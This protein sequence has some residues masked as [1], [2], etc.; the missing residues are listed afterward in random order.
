VEQDIRFCKT[1]DGVR[2]A[3]AT[4]GK[5]DPPL[6]RVLGWFTHLE[7]E[8]ENPLWRTSID[9][10]SENHLVVRYD[11]RCMGLSDRGVRTLGMETAVT[12]LETVI[13]AVGLDKVALMGLSAGGP[14]AIMYALRYPDRVSHLILYGTFVRLP[15]TVE[16]RKMMLEMV[17]FGWDSD[18]SA[19]RQFF[20]SLFMP[21]NPGAD[22]IKAFNDIQR[23]SATADDVVA[24]LSSTPDDFDLRDV[25]PQVRT[26]TLVVH[27]RGD[28]IVPFE[29]GREIAAGIPGARFQPVDGSNHWF[30]PSEAAGRT[31]INAMLDFVGTTIE[32][33]STSAQAPSGLVTILFTD[34]VGS[35]D[36]TQRVGDDK[37]QE[38]LR[39]HNAV[40]RQAL[41]E[42]DGSEIKH[43][44]DGIMASFDTVVP[45][46]QCAVS[47]QQRLA[48]HRR[49]AEHPEVRIGISA[50][51]PVTEHNDL[52]G[53]AVQLAARACARADVNGIF[54][55][56]TVREHCGDA[57]IELVERGPFELKGF[58]EPVPLFEVTWQPSA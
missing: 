26:P 14:A 16:E 3:Y 38:A 2:I 33:A 54:V 24:W 47:V 51:E 56:A 42:H 22:D 36:L 18:V 23:L 4:S 58:G 8:W 5:G 35:T 55:S 19:H 11:G 41:K 39:R 20:T 25:L 44:G 53:S 30:L 7:Y 57:A 43:T 48:D 49:N 40:V 52:F 13:D 9:L 1:P 17:R 34:M 32:S 21:D 15:R 10:W 27:R 12:D 29:L 46:I 50:G 28:A 31:V 45:A 37:A 6:V